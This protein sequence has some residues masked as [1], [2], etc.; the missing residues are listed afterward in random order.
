[1]VLIAVD[2]GN[3]AL[4]AE[5]DQ[6]LQQ[7][8]LLS[9][10][11]QYDLDGAICGLELRKRGDGVDASLFVSTGQNDGELHGKLSDKQ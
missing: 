1:M 6:L 5:I 3:G 4:G 9:M 8:S 2:G 10:A 11:Q 7:R